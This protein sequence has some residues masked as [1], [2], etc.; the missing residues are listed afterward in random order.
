MQVT[1][2]VS[3]GLKREFQ[4]TVPAADLEARLT[5]KLSELKDRVQLKGFRPGKVPITH[6]RKVYGRSVMAEAIDGVIREANAKIVEERGFKLA[7]EPK[8][9]IPNQE[10]EVDRVISGQS[11]LAYT[12][13]LE[14]LPKIEFG[15]FKSIKLDRLHGEVTPEEVDEALAKL[16]EQNKPYVAKGEG[17]RVEKGDRVVVDFTGKLDGV[18]FEG[19]TG[20]DIGVNVGSGTFIPGFEDQLI[21]MAAGET[22]TVNVTF[23]ANY[24]N[25]ELAGKAAEF[26]VTAKAIEAPGTV[27]LD[28]DYA[29]TLGLESL[30]KLKEVVKERVA[31]EHN[32]MSRQKL[33]RSLL[34]QLD[35]MHKFEPPPTLVN[36]EFNNVWQAIEND[37]KQQGRTFADEGTT[38]EKAREEYLAI[39]ERRVRLG[40]VL[41]EIGELTTSR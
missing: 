2:T 38:E 26:Q 30:D 35:Q 16:A 4:V 12:L 28:D 41:A 8:I 31:H 21:G 37:L 25:A 40:L 20:G 36:D 39:A 22:R 5:G 32:A 18:P 29:K 19:G 24:A 27:T 13:A 17:V 34:D 7:M 6:L 14:V 33:K 23:P 10:T 1:E 3:D 11:D 9:T 15:D